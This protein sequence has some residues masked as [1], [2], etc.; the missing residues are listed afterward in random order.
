MSLC[1]RSAVQ[2]SRRQAT[3]SKPAF[4][5][6]KRQLATEVQSTP[7]ALHP[8]P[9]SPPPP[10]Q[11]TASLPTDDPNAV[12]PAQTV[13]PVKGGRRKP[14]SK[15][16]DGR[17]RTLETMP[18]TAYQAALKYLREDRSEKLEH[19][20][21]E[22]AKI[23]AWKKH[24]GTSD[25][26]PDIKKMEE[27]IDKIKLDIDKNNPRIKY[28]YD[29]KKELIDP[30][31]PIYQYW[32]NN[33][34]RSMKRKVLVQRL[35]QMYVVPDLLQA[36][37]PIVDV[38]LRFS[39]S[40]ISP[41]AKVLSNKTLNHPSIKVT[42]F[43]SKE[44]LVTIVVVDPDRPNLE[45]NGFDFYLQWMVTNCPLSITDQ[46]TIGRSPVYGGR[47]EVAP[48]EP[49]YVYKGEKYHRYC[50]FIFEQKGRLEVGKGPTKSTGELPKTGDMN[51]TGTSVEGGE[52]PSLNS[53][54]VSSE[55]SVPTDPVTETGSKD[56][57]K[58]TSEDGS[59]TAAIPS[60]ERIQRLGF[61]LRSFVFKHDL[62]AIGAHMW[63]VE[64][65]HYMMDVMKKIGIKDWDKKFVK[66]PEFV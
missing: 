62:T 49:P 15:H 44:R 17:L 66:H 61:N 37:D 27:F 40:T 45:K 51:I 55:V 64:Y 41:G 21:E 36:I 10:V 22:R 2:A 14:K 7:G 47:D 6:L 33:D 23:A 58:S 13:T 5:Y 52:D 25:D 46:L 38:R 19:I 42:P 39:R 16:L 3:F 53:E 63:R 57:L 12:L 30:H 59:D 26:D 34:W 18:F 54:A 31:R 9:S 11:T 8:T 1:A 32:A 4:L 48:Y 29:N 20:R 56:I 35:E 50:L 24:K 43:D 65:D 60:G 28:M